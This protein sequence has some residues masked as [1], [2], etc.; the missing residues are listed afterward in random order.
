M[1]APDKRKTPS[2]FKHP[3]DAADSQVNEMSL[4]MH[5]SFPCWLFI[6]FCTTLLQISVVPKNAIPL[7]DRE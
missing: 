7:Y 1:S 2:Q 5:S 4:Q 3:P 6:W